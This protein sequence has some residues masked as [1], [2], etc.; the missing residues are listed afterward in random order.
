MQNNPEDELSE[1]SEVSEAPES[2]AFQEQ[3][4][5]EPAPQELPPQELPPPASPAP[6][7][8]PS[9]LLIIIK[10]KLVERSPKIELVSRQKLKTSSRRSF[11]TYGAGMAAAASGLWWLLPDEAKEQLGFPTKT[12]KLKKDFLESALK[13][14]DDVATALFS[15]DRLVPTYHKSDMT[16]VPNNFAGQTPDPAFIDKWRLMLTGLAGTDTLYLSA[17][18]IQKQF[19]THE[20]ITRLVCVEGWSAISWWGGMRF[21][22]LITKYPPRPGTKWCQIR[23]EV[24]LDGDGNS[25][26]YFV[27]FDILSALHPQTLLATQHNGKPL[28]LEHGAPLRLLAPMKLG[29]KNIKAITS[30]SYHL[31]EPDDYWNKDGYSYYD[32]I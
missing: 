16:E 24:N 6:A 22:D 19:Q 5:Q 17:A 28:E 2:P 11:L 10:D 31:N 13:F 25:D 21:G 18:D 1:V 8:Q 29:L 23:S 30:I 3:T 15:K 4:P 12:G 27:S 20:Q 9:G 14:D 26:P 32:G 7:K